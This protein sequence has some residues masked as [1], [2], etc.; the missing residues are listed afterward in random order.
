[1][2]VDFKVANSLLLNLLNCE[3]EGKVEL[4]VIDLKSKGKAADVC[5][6]STRIAAARQRIM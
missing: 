1:L 4:I 2:F 3:A 5:K 6:T